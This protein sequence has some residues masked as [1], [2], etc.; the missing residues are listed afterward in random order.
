[1]FLNR[2]VFKKIMAIMSDK[3][4][5]IEFGK[6]PND[7]EGRLKFIL[8]DKINNE[9]FIKELEKNSKKIKRIKW[10]KLN[11]ILWKVIRPQARPRTTSAGGFTHIYVPNAKS[12]S[13]WFKKYA[14]EHQLPKI[15]T[16]CFLSLTI[17]E[18][19]PSSYSIKKKYLAENGLIKPWKRTGDFDNYAK[20]IADFIQHGLL[21]DDCLVID[22]EIKL[23]YSIKPRV[24]IFCKWM[25]KFPE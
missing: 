9:K 8:G 11:L 15:E 17:Y 5:N 25:D 6:I 21:K 1:M 7:L 16:P 3:V 4:Y 22:S 19:T 12:Y 18:K 2:K 14:Q 20:G 13:E 10:N 24:E 23:F